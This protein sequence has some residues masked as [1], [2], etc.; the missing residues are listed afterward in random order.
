MN[1]KSKKYPPLK[2]HLPQKVSTQDH[3]KFLKYPGAF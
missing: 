2:E 3:R 1:K